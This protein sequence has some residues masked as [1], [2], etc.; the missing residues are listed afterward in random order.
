MP[1]FLIL[2]VACVFFSAPT[3]PGGGTPPVSSGEAIKQDLLAFQRCASVL[4]VAAHPDDENTQLITYFSRGLGFRAAYVSVTRG[5]GGQ[6]II[7]AEFGD[8]LG[9]IRTQELI[10]ARKID[11]GRQFFTRA[12][13]FGFS[14]S[15]DETLRIWDRNAVLADMVRIIRE[16]RPDVIVTRFSPQPGKTHGH[17]TASAILAVDAFALAGNPDAY[18]DQLATLQP[19]QAKRIVQNGRFGGTDSEKPGT[20]SFDISGTDPISGESFDA[21]AAKSRAM[22]VSQGFAGF[23]GRG[24]GPRMESFQPLAGEPARNDLFDGIDTTWGRFAGGAELVAMIAQAVAAFDPQSPQKSVPALLALRKRATALPTNPAVVEKRK[25]LDRIIAACLGLRVRAGLSNPEITPGENFGMRLEATLV[26]TAPVRWIAARFPSSG[27]VQSVGI[28]LK[29][30]IS[31]SID[32][33]SALPASTP[34]TQ[35]YWLREPGADGIATVSDSRLIGKPED[36][37]AF[38]VEF[39]FEIDDQKLVVTDEPVAEVSTGA[40]A[41]QRLTVV[42][43]VTVSFRPL[44]RLFAPGSTRTVQV[45]LAAARPVASGELSLNTPAGWH[46]APESIPFRFGASG[47]RVTVEFQVTAPDRVESAALTA[48]A[49]IG[50]QTYGARRIDIR[51]D[52]IAH[53][54]L[55]PQATLRVVSVDLAVRGKHIGYLPGAGDSVAECLAQM[56]FEVKTLDGA[57]LSPARLAGLDAV[58]VGVRALNVRKDLAHALP[59]LVAFAEAGGTVVMQYNRPE[60]AQTNTLGPFE[61]T[62]SADRVTDERAPVTLLARGHPILT[63]PNAIAAADF[64]GWV[65]ERGLAFPSRWDARFAPLLSCADPGEQPLKG[66]LLVADV[67]KG[68]FIYTSLAWFRQLPAGVPGAYRLFAN[69]VAPAQ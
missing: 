49:R 3:A 18:P 44:V 14:K 27:V 48:S 6:N 69:L 58:V 45:E 46:A 23:N 26:A 53:Q 8:E 31:A 55:Q 22:H 10:E 52:H 38:P 35:P 19:W 2:L 34:L 4:Y 39:I 37:P 50:A 13:D 21:I 16:F 11:G 59:A 42:P 28:D 15:S 17:H 36:P 64:D 24:S 20:I 61:L 7:G 40:H 1:Q 30:G 29:P 60:G 9:V 56:G 12:I 47:E 25:Q 66:G 54:V 63:S 33:T 65:Q 68:R 67:G 57:D 62:L 5:D 43:P 51:Y 32:S 41:G